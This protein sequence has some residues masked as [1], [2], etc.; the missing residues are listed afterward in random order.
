MLKYFDKSLFKQ[1]EFLL[2]ARSRKIVGLEVR[3]TLLERNTVKAISESFEN[4]T[5]EPAVV[6]DNRENQKR[7]KVPHLINNTFRWFGD[8][9]GADNAIP[10]SSTGPYNP[11]SYHGSTIADLN[12]GDLFG[13][14]YRFEG[15]EVRDH[16]QINSNYGA[17]FIG[18]EISH[19]VPV[20]TSGR[21]SKKFTQYVQQYTNTNGVLVASGR[22]SQSTDFQDFSVLDH[23]KYEGAKFG[24]VDATI[25]GVINYT[26]T[27]PDCIEE[28][29]I[30][31]I[32]SPVEVILVNPNT[33]VAQA[34][35]AS[36]ALPPIS[37][38]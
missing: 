1:I 32:K 25:G 13:Y 35:N 6:A 21:T 16:S 37:L 31:G 14:D 38:A 8:A 33:P 15:T 27:D 2:P 22:I 18:D 9:S 23:L 29:I 12:V 36:V 7:E 20:Y 11:G 30:P 28:G 5:F 4:R 34:N 19:D 26:T 24:T 10:V 17:F 3:P